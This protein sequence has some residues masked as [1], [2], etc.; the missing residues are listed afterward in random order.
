MS[1]LYFTPYY[2]IMS[3]C[4]VNFTLYSYL[5]TVLACVFSDLNRFFNLPCTHK[6]IEFLPD[7]NDLYSFTLTVTKY[8]NYRSHFTVQDRVGEVPVAVITLQQLKKLLARVLDFL[9]S[10]SLK[11]L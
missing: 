2:Y 10:R 11:W 4:T 8:L 1:K 3:Y 5:P 6:V 9:N 7:K